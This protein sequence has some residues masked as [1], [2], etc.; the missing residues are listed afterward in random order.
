MNIAGR[1]YAQA[2]ALAHTVLAHASLAKELLD[3]GKGANGGTVHVRDD[4]VKANLMKMADNLRDKMA[5]WYC[6]VLVGSSLEV[7]GRWAGGVFAR[8]W[9]SP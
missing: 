1:R 6:S 4:R 8:R 9:T 7:V 3:A 5:R 2:D